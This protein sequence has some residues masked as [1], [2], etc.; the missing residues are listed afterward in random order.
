[1]SR[2]S[3]RRR[4]FFEVRERQVLII[5]DG[6]EITTFAGRKMG[7]IKDISVGKEHAKGSKQAL[8]VSFNSIAT[9]C[10]T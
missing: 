4:W 10:N 5:R 8:L 9:T 7:P 6:E 1:M 3:K 2:Q